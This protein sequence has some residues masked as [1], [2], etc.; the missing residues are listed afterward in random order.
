MS[1]H[2]FEQF[3]ITTFPELT[4]SNSES[5]IHSTIA[6]QEAA[7]SPPKE[8][9]G[10]PCRRRRVRFAAKPQVFRHRSHLHDDDD[11]DTQPSKAP[12]LWYSRREMAQFR[13]DTHAE[14][15]VMLAS[16]NPHHHAWFLSLLDAYVGL[17]NND[18]NKVR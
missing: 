8:S 11:D 15:N 2:Y 9:R 3:V 13:R 12:Q 18:S 17:R 1:L 4:R 14:V 16:T 10:M 6:V 5:S 7:I